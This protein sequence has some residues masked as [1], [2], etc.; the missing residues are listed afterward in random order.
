[1]AQGGGGRSDFFSR[2]EISEVQDF[3]VLEWASFIDDLFPYDLSLCLSYLCISQGYDFFYFVQ[4]WPGSYCDTKRSCCYPAT[5]KP[6]TDF[7]I[8]GLWPQYNN[9]TYPSSC[10]QRSQFDE[11]KVSDLISRME[12]SWPTFNCGKKSTNTK[13]WTHEWTKHGTC[14]E[15]V[16]DQHA[17]F[18]AALNIK[19][20]VNLLEM[21]K[22]AG[23]L[24]D[25]KFYKLEDM[26]EAIKL[27]TGHVPGIECNHD[28][29]G[30][31]QLYQIF[32]CV[33]AT[34]S[35]VIECPVVPIRKCDTLIQFPVF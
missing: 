34:G 2:E 29:S 30:N 6:A 7:T 12:K 17:Y 35:N 9:N 8:H 18:A 26:E 27:G 15:T 19:D 20:K 3:P 25:G 22:N 21:L 14:S 16:L 31:V 4:Q 13:F 23:I 1:M 32:L 11:T 33:D 5:G 24:P 10:N 28:A